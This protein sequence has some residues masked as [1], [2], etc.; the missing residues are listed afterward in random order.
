MLLK[1]LLRWV[2]TI[3]IEGRVHKLIC[4]I[5]I[6]HLHEAIHNINSYREDYSRVVFCRYT[7]QS[8]KIAKLKTTKIYYK[9]VLKNIPAAW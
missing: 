4:L 5:V 2:L 6:S 8:L 7:V 3:L 9:S 1:L